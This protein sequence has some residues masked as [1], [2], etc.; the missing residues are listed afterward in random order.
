MNAMICRNCGAGL[1]ADGINTSLGIVACSH[2]GSLHR[3]TDGKADNRGNETVV[4][5]AVKPKNIEVELPKKFKLERAA[6][7]LEVTWA[8]GGLFQGFVITLIA[9]GFAYVAVTSGLLPLLIASAGLLYLAAAQAFNEHRIRVDAARLEVGQ[10]PLPWKGSRKLDASDII[11]LFSTRHEQR[12]QVDK[13]GSRRVDVRSYYR[14]SAKTR[15]SGRVTILSALRDP[16]Q[17]LWLEQEIESLLGI[18]DQ[19]VA[20]EHI[21]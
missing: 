12:T 7:G 13:D 3:I 21:P 6:G 4:K 19:P 17:A 11:Q 15:S 14:L 18:A 8:V 16:L 5:P 20:G 10:G 1:D 2:C 9:A